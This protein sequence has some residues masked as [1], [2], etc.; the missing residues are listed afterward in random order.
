M[1]VQ[2]FPEQI[3]T[4]R[5]VLRRPQP[6]DAEEIFSQYA[7]DAEVTKYM[8]WPRHN[9]VKVTEEV[10]EFWIEQWKGSSGGA[11]LIAD[12]S[13]DE[14]LGSTGFELINNH[15][16]STGYVLARDQWGKGY[17]TEASMSMVSLARDLGIKR[18][19]AYCH[20][21]HVKSARVLEKCGFEFEG[22]LRNYLEFP[23]LSPGEVSD[24][25]MYGWIPFES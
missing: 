4:D 15:T 7:N 2:N 21:E 18:F 6:G 25:L 13:T 19:Y 1:I 20:H 24:V 12:K 11:Y 3:L 17:A 23:N 16:G 22:R 9:S 8:S 10:V 5:L 14:I